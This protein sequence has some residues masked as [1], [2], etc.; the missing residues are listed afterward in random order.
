MGEAVLNG[1]SISVIFPC[2]N[3]ERNIAKQVSYADSILNK[4]ADDYEII[5]IND[6]STDKSPALLQRMASENSKIK[7][8]SHGANL[9][10]GR[11]LQSGFRAASKDLVFYTNTDNQYDV[12]EI[13]NFLAHI[14]RNDI[15]IG[16]R[17]N[18]GD[19]PHRILISAV[20]NFMV[21]TLFGLKA[22]DINC[23]FKLF[24]RDSLSRLE[25]KSNHFFVDAEI[26]VKATRS[27]LSIEQLQIRHYPR[28]FG[29]TTVRGK[30]L[31]MTFVEMIKFWKELRRENKPAH[32]P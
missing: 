14:N 23:A 21:R 19:F 1:K 3:E 6:G 30:R 27:G 20:Y 26:L 22:R 16:Y 2:Y 24:K 18:R 8:I 5:V 32:T 11:A 12:G 9:G 13:S 10:F 25:I 31:V 15:V 7:V 28:T 17:G 4:I 29:S